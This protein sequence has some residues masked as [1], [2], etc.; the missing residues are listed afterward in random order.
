MAN[1]AG[2]RPWALLAAFSLGAFWLAYSRAPTGVEGD[3]W[4]HLKAGQLILGGRAPFTTNAFSFTAEGHPWVQ[5]EW[6]GEVAAAWLYGLAGLEGIRLAYWLLLAAC[7]GLVAAVFRAAG[8]S[9]AVSAF[10]ALAV[11]LHLYAQLW[12]RMQGFTLLGTAATVLLLQ[13]RW[14]GAG[15]GH[16]VWLYPAAVALWANLHGGVI[17]G[18]VCCTLALLPDLARLMRGD[19]GGQDPR[20]LALMAGLSWLALLAT[21]AGSGLPAFIFATFTDAEFRAMYALVAE[22]GPFRLDYSTCQH[23]LAW[24]VLLAASVLVAGPRAAPAGAWALFLPWAVLAFVSRRHLPLAAIASAPLAAWLLT[25]ALGRLAAAPA[26]RGR[27]FNVVGTLAVA[28]MLAPPALDLAFA[29]PFRTGLRWPS[30]QALGAALQEARAGRRMFNLYDWGGLLIF[31]G[32]PEAKVFIDG[33]Q[34]A[35]GLD[36]NLAHHRIIAAAP[37]WEREM[38]R[39]GVDAV[40]VPPEAPLVRALDALP[41]WNEVHSDPT[42][43]VFLKKNL[44]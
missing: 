20:P 5:H 12:P 17:A 23:F 31:H 10:G 32:Y 42:A 2:A 15:L 14:A 30:P 26:V 6:L 9:L 43:V 3:L 7:F 24:C 16:A 27:A 25:A 39:W 34:D 4:W 13:R 40:F 11:H 33:R 44:P 29:R 18:P 37:G 38:E 19:P 41:T 21:P 35:Y 28:F 1:P 22:W 36:L 8:C